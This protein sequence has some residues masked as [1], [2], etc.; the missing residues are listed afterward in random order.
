[1]ATTVTHTVVEQVELSNWTPSG[2]S[3]SATDTSQAPV[4]G[5]NI[6]IADDAVIQQLKPVDGGITA[7]TVLITAFVFEA[8]LWGTHPSSSPTLTADH[9]T[10]RIPHI[11]RRLRRILFHHPRV[12]IQLLKNS[13]NRH[14]RTRALL[15]RCAFLR[16]NREALPRVPTT[17]NMGRLAPLHPRSRVRIIYFHRQRLDHHPGNHVRRRFRHIVLSNH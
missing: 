17:A 2:P 10:P 16:F 11:F 13:P 12:R 9:V 4:L 14:A 15:P 3:R 5:G 8:V 7:W 1:M 6:A